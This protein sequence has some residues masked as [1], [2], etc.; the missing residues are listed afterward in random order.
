MP[1][2][3]AGGANATPVQG[4]RY[5]SEP[6]CASGPDFEHDRQHVGGKPVSLSRQRAT[7]EGAR[8][9]EIARIAEARAAGLPR[10]Q[11]QPGPLGNE[12]ALLLGERCV[13]VEH[14]WVGVGS[15]LRHDEGHPLGHEAGHEGHVAREAVELGHY[16]RHFF[17]RAM[18]RAAAS[19]G[20][21]S[22]ASVPLP[23]SASTY[24]EVISR[25]SASAKR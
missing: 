4:S 19:W 3:P 2:S 15:E 9:V 20:R 22:S 25:P 12:P 10:R 24:S 18:F 5:G 17:T 23:V 16:D 11:R 21:R 1:A 13:E 7:A 14:E 6:P 8:F